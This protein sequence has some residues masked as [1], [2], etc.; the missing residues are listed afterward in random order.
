[1]RLALALLAIQILIETVNGVGKAGTR[2]QYCHESRRQDLPDRTV[3]LQQY[4]ASPI[5]SSGRNQS[6]ID[7]VKRNR[8]KTKINDPFRFTT[9]QTLRGVFP[10]LKVSNNG[11]SVQVTPQKTENE[12]YSM[13]GVITQKRF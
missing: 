9:S 4:K 1:M 12:F 11:H 8:I 10:I 13:E 7:I 5:C 3:C 2:W 6:P